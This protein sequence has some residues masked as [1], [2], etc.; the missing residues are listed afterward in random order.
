MRFAAA[1]SVVVLPVLSNGCITQE[2]L[3]RTGG[4]LVTIHFQYSSVSIWMTNDAFIDQALVL[5]AAGETMI[6]NFAHVIEGED[7][8]T[9]WSWHVDP[10]NAEWAD[11]TI[12]VCDAAPEYIEENLDAWLAS[13]GAWCPW[14]VTSVEVDDR[15]EG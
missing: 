15:R 3:E 8:D 14:S 13:P 12:E 5:E 4:A 9:Q 7:C 6:P 2:C 1:I 11:F 10:Q